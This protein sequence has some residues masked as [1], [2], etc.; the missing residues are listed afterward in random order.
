VVSAAKSGVAIIAT[1]TVIALSKFNLMSG[2]RLSYHNGNPIGGLMGSGWRSQHLV[3]QYS[4][5]SFRLP[6]PHTLS[7]VAI[8]WLPA[9][10]SWEGTT[11]TQIRHGHPNHGACRAARL[12]L[13]VPLLFFDQGRVGADDRRQARN[14]PPRPGAKASTIKPV[15]RR[16]STQSEPQVAPVGLTRPRVTLIVAHANMK[17][18]LIDRDQRKVDPSLARRCP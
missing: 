14:N 17:P 11:R 6:P 7:V 13:A 12:F 5:P 15:P 8:A 4:C 1:N 3:R 18:G 2:L 10:S 9:F 16:Q